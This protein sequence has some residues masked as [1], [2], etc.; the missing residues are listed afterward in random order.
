MG[1]RATPEIKAEARSLRDLGWTFGAISI[2]IGFNRDTVSRWLNPDRAQREA[3]RAYGW[4]T[5][6]VREKP[7]SVYA[8]FFPASAV[9]KVGKKKMG[10]FKA[11]PVIAAKVNL[12]KAGRDTYVDDARLIW[13]Q[14]GDCLEE[15]WVQTNIAFALRPAFDKT[16]TGLGYRIKLTEWFKTD[17]Y[18]PEELQSMLDDIYSRMP[19]ITWSV[20]LTLWKRDDGD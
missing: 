5:E 19:E 6:N 18:P 17:S 2:K 20:D 12:R 16:P 4:W 14:P 11:S 1:S 9:M 15:Q 10:N 8:V 7:C 3:E 13:E